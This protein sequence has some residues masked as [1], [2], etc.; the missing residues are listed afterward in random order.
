[1]TSNLAITNCRRIVQTCLVCVLITAATLTIFQLYGADT[2]MPAGSYHGDFRRAPPGSNRYPKP[3]SQFLAKPLCK[4]VLYS[5]TCMHFGHQPWILQVRLC[6]T[7]CNVWWLV[8]VNTCSHM[9]KAPHVAC[10]V[11]MLCDHAHTCQHGIIDENSWCASIRLC[12]TFQVCRLL[13]CWTTSS[14]TRACWGLMWGLRGWLSPSGRQLLSR[15]AACCTPT[16]WKDA[17]VHGDA[18]VSL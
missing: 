10:G 11:T 15:Y 18:N 6:H 17:H 13:A 7:T 8:H 3:P 5:I 16:T 4:P 12:W 9:E 1:M 14:S 2:A